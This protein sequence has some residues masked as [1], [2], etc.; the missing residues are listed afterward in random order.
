M[1]AKFGQKPAFPSASNAKPRPFSPQKSQ[2]LRPSP[3]GVACE[4]AQ[5]VLT[6]EPL[7]CHSDDFDLH[8]QTVLDRNSK[9]KPKY[10][11]LNLDRPFVARLLPLI[12]QAIF[13][14]FVIMK[15]T[16]PT[17]CDW[18]FVRMTMKTPSFELKTRQFTGRRQKHFT[19]K[20]K[21]FS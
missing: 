20:A 8:K 16:W 5:N 10:R 6:A 3:S 19:G 4:R 7:R 9:G 15:P 21:A 11:F 17:L 13:R 18:L 2:W 14:N 12:D 1:F